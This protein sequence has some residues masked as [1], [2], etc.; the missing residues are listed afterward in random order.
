[1]GLESHS[2]LLPRQNPGVRAVVWAGMQSA[3]C[4]VARAA[5]SNAGGTKAGDSDTP[6]AAAGE[7]R[8]CRDPA[9]A[10]RASHCRA[11]PN[12]TAKAVSHHSNPKVSL[13]FWQS[14][15]AVRR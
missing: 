2:L 8:S 1:M 14:P 6:S 7:E 5:L 3:G 11:L 4:T 9:A 12:P 10:C 13:A 15:G